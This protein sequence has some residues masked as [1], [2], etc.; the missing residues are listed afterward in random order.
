M[1]REPDRLHENLRRALAEAPLHSPLGRWMAR[2]RAELEALFR[3]GQPDWM[4][5][6]AA[7]GKAGL[8]DEA[9]RTPTAES[10]ERAWR[11]V[12]ERRPS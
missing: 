10:A 4:K 9:E 12:Q 2:Q 7:F 8:R 3:E 11:M 1:P 6:A 5:M